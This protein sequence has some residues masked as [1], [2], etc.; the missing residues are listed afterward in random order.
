MGVERE[1]GV[2]HGDEEGEDIAHVDGSAVVFLGDFQ[3]WGWHN[4]LPSQAHVHAKD[5][6]SREVEEH[7]AQRLEDLELHAVDV[8][9]VHGLAAG[10]IDPEEVQPEV[11]Q[12]L[13]WMG[14]A[15]QPPHLKALLAPVF[16]SPIHDDGP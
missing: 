11:E 10:V 14:L 1:A 5:D 3:G 2:D 6:H 4:F 8:A 7:P 12:R 9:H 16:C 15:V 13:P